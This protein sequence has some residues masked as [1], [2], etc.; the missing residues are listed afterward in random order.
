MNIIVAG[1]GKIGITIIESLVNEGHD[2]TAVDSDIT[3]LN[4]VKHI[5]DIITVH[6]NA[7]DPDTLMKAHT[8]DA[9]LIVSV[10][11]SDEVNMLCCFFARKLGTPH[12][13]AR[14]RDTDYNDASLGFIRSKLEMSMTINPEY[15]AAKELF[16]ILKFPSALK[17]ETFSSRRF[18]MIELKLHDSALSGK[19]ICEL[20]EHFKQK[21][22]I[23]A[24]QRGDRVFI[25]DGNFILEDGD[26]IGLT[27]EPSEITKLL[28]DLKILKKQARSI[29]IFGG[30]RTGYY[31]ARRLIAAGNDVKII[32]R[33]LERCQD[34]CELLPQAEICHGDGA[35]KELLEE[36]GIKETDAFVALT[37]LDEENI[38]MAF[39]AASKGVPKVISKVN[40]E[41]LA[42]IAERMG[43]ETIV[44]PKKMI[45]DVLVQ[46]AR[47]LQ[48]SVGSKVETL[49]KLMDSNVEALEF[50]ANTD[51]KGLEIP[52]KDLK[53]KKNILIAGLVRD[54]MTIIPTGADYILPQDKVI[55]I[56]AA[57]KLNDLAD[58]MK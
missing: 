3:A 53:M 30:S 54:R 41:E 23:C 16:N 4:N 26:K 37:G 10:T 5:Y 11:N 52:L 46:Y 8:E 12:T 13:I 33:V 27:A 43:L 55:V 40:R 47:A 49:Y 24:V 32:E 34:L 38:L 7:A 48:N 51:F 28:K 50:T 1:C 15:L 14:V 25:P 21:F 20:R 39:L 35:S 2:V 19:K 22:L 31:L 58:I 29:I 44:S 6:G 56:S 45:A 9:D 57:G 18:E 36:E 42:M 17:I